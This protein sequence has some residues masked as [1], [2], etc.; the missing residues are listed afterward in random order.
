MESVDRKPQG[1]IL[2]GGNIETLAPGR[3][4]AEA[5]GVLGGKIAAVGALEHVRKAVP[6]PSEQID[7][8][9]ATVLPG[10][11]DACTRL[12]HQ[13]ERALR[14]NL[15]SAANLP[16]ILALVEKAINVLG[17]REW[18]VGHGWDKNLWGGARFPHRAD[19]DLIAPHHR[20]ALYSMDRRVVW[21]N[22]EGLRAAGIKHN[23]P[24][25]PG[26]EIE[27]DPVTHAA[28]G[29]L[30]EEAVR[31]IDRIL[32]DPPQ[33]LL[34]ESLMDTIA[35]FHARGIT[36][37]QDISPWRG[38]EQLAQLRQTGKLYIRVWSCPDWGGEENL[39]LEAHRTGDGDRMFT[40]GHVALPVDGTLQSLTAARPVP[41]ESDVNNQGL[42][43]LDDKRLEEEVQR[44]TRLGWGTR[45]RAQGDVGAAM[46]RRI[47]ERQSGPNKHILDLPVLMP[48]ELV[49]WLGETRHTVTIGA[50]RLPFDW[51]LATR[52]WPDDIG[53][54]YNLKDLYEQGAVLQAGS[55]HPVEYWTIFDLIAGLIGLKRVRHRGESSSI[56]PESGRL[57]VRQAL[58]AFT[59]Q[60]AKALGQLD[61][62][63]TLEEEKVADLV[64]LSD[65]PLTVPLEK[66]TGIKVMGTMVSGNWVF[67]DGF[68]VRLS[69]AMRRVLERL[70][71]TQEIDIPQ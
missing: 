9:G 17:H 11:H 70:A 61:W 6:D 42:I 48:P 41:Y 37:V 10:F 21:L 56:W 44:I 59:M 65:N 23:T 53:H 13:S 31:R 18:I 55:D 28:T 2:R 34:V 71:A 67:A 36:S 29:I 63:G 38:V 8:D 4:N 62:C 25:P 16:E 22:T 1:V 50:Y 69:R 66:L 19:I 7:L 39:P 5:L 43:V 54:A 40:Y 46:A 26:G 20:V 45:L 33:E 68:Q 64:V 14:L 60:P 15:Y 35:R 52:E 49:Q 32:P 30:K 51:L 12:F 57:T 27:R 58:E 47:L 24:N 3:P